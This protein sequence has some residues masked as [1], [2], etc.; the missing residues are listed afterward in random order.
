M[1]RL[2]QVFGGWFLV[3]LLFRVQ[4]QTDQKP[5]TNDPLDARTFYKKLTRVR[6]RKLEDIPL[7]RV[8]LRLEH[9]VLK[10]WHAGFEG[11]NELS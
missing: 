8:L 4:H 3:G 6:T 7:E 11:H 5:K 2:Q 10:V 1:L 9:K